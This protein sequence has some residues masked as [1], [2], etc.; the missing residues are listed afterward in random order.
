MKSRW[1]KTPTFSCRASNHCSGMW[2]CADT[3]SPRTAMPNRCLSLH[4]SSSQGRPVV[5]SKPKIPL[6]FSSFTGSPFGERAPGRILLEKSLQSLPR[7]E[8]PRND[9]SV[10]NRSPSMSTRGRWLLKTFSKILQISL[11]PGMVHIFEEDSAENA[12]WRWRSAAPRSAK[13]TGEEDFDG[14]NRHWF[15][16]G[17]SWQSFS[18]WQITSGVSFRKK[19]STITGPKHPS[20]SLSWLWW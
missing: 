6:Q 20:L 3:E 16:P 5:E 18:A 10:P 19:P 15:W 7:H 8:L 17:S 9:D 12:G 4:S 2:K 11:M 13:E 14:N 1:S